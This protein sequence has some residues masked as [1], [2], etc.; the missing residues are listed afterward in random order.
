[1]PSCLPPPPSTTTLL[2]RLLFPPAPVPPRHTRRSKIG[3]HVDRAP[4][5]A[6]Y[7]SL[8]EFQV[9][10]PGTTYR[11]FLARMLDG[12]SRTTQRG[13]HACS[14]LRGASSRLLRL[15]AR[16][17]RRA[18]S[19]ISA[20][21]HRVEHLLVRTVRANRNPIHLPPILPSLRLP[22]LS[23]RSPLSLRVAATTT[24]DLLL[25]ITATRRDLGF[26]WLWNV[27]LRSGGLGETFRGTVLGAIDD[28][29]NRGEQKHHDVARQ[30]QAEIDEA[31]RVLWGT[32]GS[33]TDPTPNQTSAQTTGYDTAPPTYQSTNAGNG[34]G[35]FR[36]DL[37]SAGGT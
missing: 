13:W 29:E 20:S 2:A 8:E 35:E 30:G 11:L 10:S 37:K 3:S 17:L 33:N 34:A 12:G 1:M 21:P 31:Y 26:I 27:P 36:P 6:F 23:P 22:P 32:S 16:A 28:L 4:G 9:D 24:H 18:A 7:A 19:R 14:T 5:P 15:R 25:G